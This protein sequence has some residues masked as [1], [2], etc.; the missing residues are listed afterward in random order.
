M[1][2][3]KVSEVRDANGGTHF[4][5]VSLEEAKRFLRDYDT[6]Y[7]IV[8]ELYEVSRVPTDHRKALA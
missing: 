5:S 7:G 8:L 2:S 3:I 4:E 6:E 1:S